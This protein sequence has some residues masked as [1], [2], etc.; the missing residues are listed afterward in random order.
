M[1]LRHPGNEACRP[2]SEGAMPT[3]FWNNPLKLPTEDMP[4]S[5]QTSVTD[6]SPWASICFALSSRA[7]IR[8]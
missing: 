7:S 4:T 2:N 8:N 5:M 3:R 1:R 6:R